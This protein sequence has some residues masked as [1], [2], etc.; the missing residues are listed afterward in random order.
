MKRRIFAPPSLVSESWRATIT[1]SSYVGTPTV[2]RV[3]PLL[4]RY[5]SK[6][7]YLFFPFTGAQPQREAPYADEVFNLRASYR[8]ESRLFA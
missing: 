8:D 2:T 3:L 6:S 1:S 7:I 4:K 5:G